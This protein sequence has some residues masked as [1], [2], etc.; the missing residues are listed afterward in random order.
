MPWEHAT[1][2]LCLQAGEAWLKEQG[3]SVKWVYAVDE[4]AVCY[5]SSAGEARHQRWRPDQKDLN[6]LVPEGPHKS[7]WTV[8]V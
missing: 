4:W 7:G 1:S 8:Y 5:V 3:R 6:T 2:G